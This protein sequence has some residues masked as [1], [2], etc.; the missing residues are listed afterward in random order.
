MNRGREAAE[1]FAE[2]RR[3]EDAAPR[4][5]DVVPSLE[6]CKLLIEDARAEA[7]SAEVSHTRRV[8]VDNAPALFVIPCGDAS[9]KDGGHDLTNVLMKGMRE[10]QTEI[11]GEDTCYGYTGSAS[12]GRILR[13]T[14]ECTYSPKP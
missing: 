3:R 2:R 5:K 6:S 1:R 8:V 14:A 7:V 4:L 10:G 12:C 13:F 9:C 11:K